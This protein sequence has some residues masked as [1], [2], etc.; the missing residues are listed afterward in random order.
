MLTHDVLHFD[1][2]L[3]S[4]MTFDAGQFVALQAPDL[5]GMRAYSMVNYATATRKLAFVV[6]RLPG[7]G[8]C[9][10]LFDGEPDGAELGVFGPLGA[11]TFHPHEGKHVLCIGGGSGIAGMMAIL[12]RA[13]DE[14]YF[15]D[16]TGHVFFGVRTMSDGFYLKEL[17]GFVDK[18]GGGLEVTVVLSDEDAPASHHPDFPALKLDT[19]FVHEGAERAMKGKCADT[20]AYVAGPPPMVDAA[21]R[22]LITEGM[23]ATDIRY[24]KYS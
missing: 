1:L 12:T 7:G 4:E 15:A 21:L 24:D 13:T 11:A 18:A 3:D 14:G 9:N 8:F 20:L 5:I 23:S 22:V 19:G 10:W 2:A 16:H 17:A 6:K